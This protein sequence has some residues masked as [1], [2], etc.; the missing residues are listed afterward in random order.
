MKKTLLILVLAANF[1]A[2]QSTTYFA[3]PLEL[4]SVP[5]STSISDSVVV[6]GTDKILKHVPRSEFGTGFAT[7]TYVDAQ[8]DLKVDKVAGERLINASEITN[9]SNQSGVNTGDNAVN[10]NYTS[11]YRAGNFIAGTNYLAPNGSASALTGF[12]VASS[13]VSGIVNNTSLQELGGADKLIN[14][15]RVGKGNN[16]LSYN[17]ALGGSALHN[18]TTGNFNNAIGGA[19][20]QSVTTGA[21]NV[22]I[23]TS[24]LFYLATGSNNTAIGHSAMSGSNTSSAGNNRNIALG[25]NAGNSIR[26][27]S[28][29]ILIGGDIPNAT[30][31][32]LQ[33]GNANTIVGKL[34]NNHITGDN[35]TLLGRWSS[36]TTALSN[37]IVLSDGA[38]N[39]GV[40]KLADN[41]L[42]AQ[43]QTNALIAANVTGKAILTKEYLGTRIGTVAP[44]TSADAGT[45]GEIRVAAGYVY[46]YVTG[47]GWLRA[48]GVT[49]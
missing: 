18:I 33:T 35:N 21:S 9:L 14:G 19:A 41:T 27:S 31:V 30:N 1:M 16:S 15:V 24:A 44:T 32:G 38:G 3:K 17:I 28:D 48:A 42:L 20:L 46:W 7:L 6:W 40:Q 12:P 34:N 13:T 11:D 29:N 49:F 39:V 4:N 26:T 5:A 37:N 22:G 23:G 47:T 36:P 25:A 10:S 45:E 8:D 2:A 43:T